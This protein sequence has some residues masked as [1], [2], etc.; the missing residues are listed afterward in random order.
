MR[1]RRPIYIF[2]LGVAIGMAIG[3]ALNSIAIGAGVGVALGI[4]MST[5]WEKS[6][7]RNKSDY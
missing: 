2:P 4:A 6:R 3:V 7:G 1:R 5:I